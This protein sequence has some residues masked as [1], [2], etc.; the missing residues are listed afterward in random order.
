[1]RSSPKGRLVALVLAVGAVL[2][3]CGGNAHEGP[4][5]RP[6]A[7]PTPVV[8][9]TDMS[10]DDV[11]AL[12]YL[13]GRRD[14]D[15]R[16]VAVSGTGIADCPE[17]ARN[18]R[19]LLAYAGRGDVPVGCGR[20]DPL[21]GANGFP[22]EWRARA[23]ELFGLKLPAA[24]RGRIGDAVEVLR[25]AIESADGKVTIL[26]LAPMTDTALLLRSGRALRDR[27]AS[28]VAMGGAAAVP[29]N[30]GAGHERSEWNL[31]IDAVA[32]REVLGSGTPITLVGLDATNDVPAT[33]YLWDVLDRHHAGARAAA[34]WRLMA[35]SG[36]FAGGQYLWD[37]LAAA[38]VVRPDV[39]TFSRKRVHV[40]TTGAD[41]GRLV[42]DPR[43]PPVRLALGAD[44]AAFERQF[45]TALIGRMRFAIPAPEQRV[46]L[47]CAD[48]GCWYRGP[49]R[50][51]PGQGTLD[52]VNDASRPF[53]HLIGRLHEGRTAADL[54]RYVRAQ[55]G[56]G[57]R[58]P[59][60][61]S[62]AITGQTPPHSTM[63]W[64]IGATA[65]DYVLV[66]TMKDPAQTWVVAGV[67]VRSVR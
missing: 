4:T 11:L 51:A 40:V 20:P 9:D 53:T 19:A 30:I 48:G 58:P 63:T 56:R 59:V 38:A 41:A 67:A 2:A 24:P 8:V 23:D 44:R 39:L 32:A 61:L 60:W 25:R 34:A 12:A 21:A 37:P 31:W 10:T 18:A 6:A 64:L 55:G 43:G 35:S 46:V 42:E 50:T 3:A 29:G 52:T 28:I 26:S 66:A 13:L 5:A 57:W 47:R 22:P 15:L 33:V 49:R 27:I 16:A 65:G 7:A 54:R 1:M 36:M 17:G 62:T 45:L 14:V